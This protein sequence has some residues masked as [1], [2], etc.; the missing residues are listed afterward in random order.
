M[1]LPPRTPDRPP[2]RTGHPTARSGATR[3]RR[4]VLA[5]SVATAALTGPSPLAGAETTASTP[6]T[7]PATDRVRTTSASGSQSVTPEI[8]PMPNSGRAPQDAGERGG[9]MQQGLFFAICAAIAGLGGL[10]WRDS[11]R[12]RRRQGRLGVAPQR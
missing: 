12:K 10:A 7:L 2:A 1:A 3:F 4:T 8:I 11:R 5:L 9:W 6:V